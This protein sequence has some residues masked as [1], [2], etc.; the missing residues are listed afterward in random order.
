MN[1]MPEE[2]PKGKGKYIRERIQPPGKFERFVTKK[3]GKNGE[4]V[5]LGI[6]KH[7]GPR[8]GTTEVQSVLVPKGMGVKKARAE[9]KKFKHHSTGDPPSDTTEQ[10]LDC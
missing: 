5:V 8:G 4:K 10:F 9:K 2:I 6:K 1:M 3:V 7:K